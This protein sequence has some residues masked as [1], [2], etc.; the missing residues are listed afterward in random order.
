MTGQTL[1]H[2]QIQ[3]K[4]GE[5]GMGVV[6][7]ALD[8]HLNRPVALKLLPADKVSNPERRRRFVQEAR[9]ASAL[10]HP[11]IVTIYDIAS[12]ESNDFIAMEFIQGKTLD[13]LQHRKALSLADTL[14]YSIQIADALAKAHAA[15]IVHRDLKP[16]NIMVTDERQ[17]KV[18]DFGLAKLVEPDRIDSKASTRPMQ[19]AA[20]KTDEAAIV[21]TAAYM[22]P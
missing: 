17:V 22:S 3:E 1:S 8:T 12:H 13:Q 10:N 16:S 6:Y 11:H 18:L 14:K 19:D 9:A 5:G 2:Y 15:G 4:L 20:P 21:G 7:R